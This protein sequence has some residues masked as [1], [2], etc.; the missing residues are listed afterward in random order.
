MKRTLKADSSG[1]RIDVFVAREIKG[2]SRSRAR[3]LIESG[4]ILLDGL[5]SKPNRKLAAGEEIT[6]DI[7]E[8]EN[9]VIKPEKIQ[10]DIVYE[11]DSV[12]IVNKPPGL[13]T[14]PTET[15]RSGT[16]VN[17]LLNYTDKLSTVNGPMRRGIV[18]RLDKGT[19]GVLIIAR[20]DA[21]HLN[22][23]AQI[24]ARTVKRC[25]RTLV[26]G[27]V[28]PDVGE[29]SAPIGR[30]SIERV[31]M[32]VKYLDGREAV[33]LYEVIDRF[34]IENE[35]I[36]YL[37][38]SL[39]TGRTHQIRVHFSSI[40][41]PVCGDQKYGKKHRLI[42]M[43]RQALHAMEVGFTH[44]ETGEDVSFSAPLPSDFKK[45]LSALADSAE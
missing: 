21:A 14:H 7:P 15:L 16:L 24:G 35:V 31:K 1:A 20:T 4:H 23:A 26:L 3:K 30:H 11:D 38:V 44:P 34:K 12:L 25:Y 28:E 43:S 6:V 32:S 29:I 13:V 45:Q 22:L 17:A 9:T 37:K 2:I 18:H 5:S 27:N 33:T 36:S 10:L 8:E 42:Q 39:K 41:Y 19:T 40:G